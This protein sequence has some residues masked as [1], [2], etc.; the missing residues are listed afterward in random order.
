MKRLPIFNYNITNQGERLDV[1]IEG[2]IV[3]A[4]TQ[5]ILKD[6]YGDETS[7]SFKSLRTDILNSGLK[8]IRI[9]INCFGG[10][11]VETE[12]ICSF[13]KE[14]ENSGYSIEG[15]G[16]GFVC[17]SATKILSSITNSKISKNSWYMVHNAS[18]YF[19]YMDVNTAER[20]SSVLRKFNDN[21][22]DFYV[23]LTQL[24]TTQ[25]QS[26]MDAETWFTGAEAVQHGFVKALIEDDYKEDFKPINQ[27]DWNFKNQNP[28]NVYNSL[29]NTPTTPPDENN[30][31]QNIDMKN[32]GTLIGGAIN[33]ALAGFNITPKNAGDNAFSVESITNA[34]NEALKEFKPEIEEE[35]LTNAV[36]KFFEKGLPENMIAQI[37]DAVK[38]TEDPTPVNITEDPEFTKIVDRVK[39]LEEKSLKNLG[40]SNPPKNEFEMEGFSFEK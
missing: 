17:S 26:W 3:D 16:V 15:K 22:R 9:T 1:Y 28:M 32:L 39:D 23:D 38:P 25:I 11:V 37:T 21:V 19:G 24:E 8:N 31:N 2:N 20:A 13:I 5:D 34:V 40:K 12:A 30:F 18:M 6:W 7:V 35:Q 10:K 27:A 14:L 33:S 36:N 29:V 4:E